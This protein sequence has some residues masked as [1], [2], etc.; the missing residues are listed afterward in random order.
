LRGER[1]GKPLEKKSG[2][3]GH[4]D[5]SK[6]NSTRQIGKAQVI[7]KRGFRNVSRRDKKPT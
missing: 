2:M 5:K 6:R 4:R 7:G 3:V 1:H